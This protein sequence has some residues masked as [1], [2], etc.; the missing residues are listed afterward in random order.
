MTRK[1]GLQ[2]ASALMAATMAF[3]PMAASAQASGIGNG[4]NA[5]A[6]PFRGIPIS[7]TVEGGEEFVGTLDIQRF[8]LVDQTIVAVGTISGK[9]GNRPVNH[10]AVAWPLDLASST[11]ASRAVQGKLDVRPASF[12][13]GASTGLQVVPAQAACDILNLVLGPLDLNILGL[14]VHLNQVELDIVAV[15]GGGL[16]GDLLCAVANLL[17]PLGAL[18]ALL[19]ALNDLLDFFNGFLSQP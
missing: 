2:V 11:S 18:I 4:P 5:S 9:M 6:N 3:A 10:Q 16:L 12:E 8:Q 7:G 1:L 17:N 14:E 15:P 13:R 19:E